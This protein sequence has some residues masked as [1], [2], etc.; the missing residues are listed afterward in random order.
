MKKLF[1]PLIALSLVAFWT[2]SISS[3]TRD[4]SDR[5]LYQGD[6][7]TIPPVIDISVPAMSQTYA[8]GNHVAIVG[9][10]SDLESEKND[11]H[12]PGFRKGELKEISIEVDNLTD[13][14]KLLISNPIVTG[15]DGYGFNERVEIING[16]GTTDCRLIIIASDAST[17]N[18]TVRDTVFFKYQ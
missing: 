5:F 16:T 13:G 10:I 14:T 1:L 15:T 7:D 6:N 8:Y 12:D 4:I 17:A 18:Y 11:I 9:T 3:C 2:I